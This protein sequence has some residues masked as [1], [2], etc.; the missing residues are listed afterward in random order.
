MTTA[1]LR[2]EIMNTISQLDDPHQLQVVHTVLNQLAVQETMTQ[3]DDDLTEE[4]LAEL[5]QIEKDWTEHP[6]KFGNWDDFVNQMRSE[7]KA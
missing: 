2:E 5:N 6:E 4:Q 7:R 1:S 3:F